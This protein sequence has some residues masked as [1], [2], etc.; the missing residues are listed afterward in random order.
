MGDSIR[1]N[2]GPV[3]R[4]NGKGGPTTPKPPLTP[5]GQASARTALAEQQKDGPAVQSREPASVV[6][7]SIDDAELDELFWRYVYPHPHRTT[8]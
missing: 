2:E 8:S 6:G 1:M 5:K 7:E 3:Q 4:G